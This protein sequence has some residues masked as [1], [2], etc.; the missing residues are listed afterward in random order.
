M[1]TRAWTTGLATLVLL[2]CV[3]SPGTAQL[4]PA[5]QYVMEN[6]LANFNRKDLNGTMNTIDTRSPDY[7]S[8][9]QALEAQFRDLDASAQ[10]VD[11]KYVGHDDEFGVARTKIKTTG[12]PGTGF[13]DNTIDAM[14][15][16]HQENGTWKLW[17]ELILGVQTS[18]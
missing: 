2:C 16:F 15:V 11:F 17:D 4:A 3:A 13:T 8:T 12:K 1:N 14:M 7:D 9:K 10:L 5:L 18:P 6:N